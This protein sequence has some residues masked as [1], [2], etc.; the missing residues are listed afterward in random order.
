MKI[1]RLHRATAVLLGIF[2]ISHLGVHLTALISKEAHLASLD[3]VQIAYR[4]VVGETL[5]VAAILTQIFTGFKRLKIKRRSTDKWARAQVLSGMYLIFFL[6]LHT[7]AALYTHHVYGVETDFYWAAGSM[8]FSPVK[9]GFAL[10]YFCAV[11]A[12]FVHFAAALH[13]GWRGSSAR[14]EKTVSALGAIIA[15]LIIF[16]FWGVLYEIVIPADV[17]GYYQKYFGIFGVN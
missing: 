2:I 16:A 14:L 15:G 4:N 3:F 6:F 9:Y 12:V 11:L 13:F 7:G 1:K 17:T 8:H 5:L 10:Y